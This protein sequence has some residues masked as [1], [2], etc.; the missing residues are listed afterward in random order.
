MHSGA[1]VRNILHLLNV[2][3][4]RKEK[5]SFETVIHFGTQKA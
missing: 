4:S 3:H 1:Y 5:K 2:C